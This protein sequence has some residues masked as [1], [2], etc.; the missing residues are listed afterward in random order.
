[1]N[2]R[3]RA[4]L[5]SNYIKSFF[6]ITKFNRVLHKGINWSWLEAGDPNAED[7]IVLLHGLAL[8]K[9]HWRHVIPCL[10]NRFQVIAP[11][12]PGLNL[13]TRLPELNSG[14]HSIA[15]HLVD[16]LKT[17]TPKRLHLV[18][19]S[20]SATL[21][22]CLALSERLPIESITLVSVADQ[23]FQSD[24]TLLN[25]QQS[26]AS[27]LKDMDYD[28]FFD[29]VN[30]IFHH[31][32]PGFQLATKVAWKDF[33]SFKP[34]VFK[35]VHQTERESSYV[36]DQFRKLDI[37]TLIIHGEQDKWSDLSRLCHSFDQPNFTHISL[38]DCGHIPF[39]EQPRLFTKK[40][41]TFLESHISS[42]AVQ[43]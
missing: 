34:F 6:G 19:H 13:N 12:I 32:P 41:A 20:M 1:M 30:S 10:S 39:L 24:N 29:W 14:Y 27:F 31:K 18:G 25:H 3:N 21:S 8:S 26:F 7:T 22:A 36:I 17:Q 9:S 15:N 11:D 28:N 2:I 42:R 33:Q 5:L 16:F 35:M 40:L 38:Q 43:S 37:E 4:F 23:D